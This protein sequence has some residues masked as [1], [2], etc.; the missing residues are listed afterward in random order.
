MEPHTYCG[1]PFLSV[2]CTTCVSRPPICL[3]HVCV[4]LDLYDHRTNLKLTKVRYHREE[5][6]VMNGYEL[7]N[8]GLR[9]PPIPPPQEF[10]TLL[11]PLRLLPNHSA[12]GVLNKEMPY[13]Q[14]RRFQVASPP[15]GQSHTR[16]YTSAQVFLEGSTKTLSGWGLETLKIS[17]SC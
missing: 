9:P 2:G 3:T 5:A 13:L 16:C 1:V 12:S 15:H 14:T 11:F 6:M 8:A 17:N 10:A 7:P 4:L